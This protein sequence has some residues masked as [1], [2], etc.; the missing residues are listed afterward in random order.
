MDT[1]GA[2][3]VHGVI[4]DLYEDL[5]RKTVAKFIFYVINLHS[6]YNVK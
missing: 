4:I 6:F 1:Y 2:N 3:I 5:E